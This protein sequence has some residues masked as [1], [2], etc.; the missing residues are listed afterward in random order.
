MCLGKWVCTCGGNR[1]SSMLCSACSTSCIWLLEAR[2]QL[3]HIVTADVIFCVDILLSLFVPSL[4]YQSVHFPSLTLLS[5]CCFSVLLPSS[6]SDLM[7]Y[8]PILFGSITPFKIIHSCG[9]MVPPARCFRLFVVPS[10]LLFP[11]KT[12]RGHN[13]LG[14]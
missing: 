7:P 2:F 13:M 14:T 11:L 12:L 1:C 4:L 10:C 5:Q 6:F 9:Y 8:F 3:V